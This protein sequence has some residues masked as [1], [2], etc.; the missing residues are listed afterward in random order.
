VKGWCASPLPR[1]SRN[2]GQPSFMP[3]RLA[4]DALRMPVTAG[5][6]TPGV[7]QKR[8]GCAVGWRLSRA[9]ETSL[10]RWRSSVNRRSTR[11]NGKRCAARCRLVGWHARLQKGGRDEMV[12]RRSSE[13]VPMLLCCTCPQ[14]EEEERQRLEAEKQRQRDKGRLCTL[15]MLPLASPHVSRL[16]AVGGAADAAASQLAAAEAANVSAAAARGDLPG[17]RSGGKVKVRRRPCQA[18]NAYLA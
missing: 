4:A 17:V 12:M 16:G 6:G 18:G 10:L 7:G 9:L 1:R 11:Q 14:L 8:S 2:R 3:G 5:Q 15:R 13:R